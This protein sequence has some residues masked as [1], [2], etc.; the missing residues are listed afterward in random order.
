[1]VRTQ[2]VWDWSMWNYLWWWCRQ[3]PPS[4]QL[5]AKAWIFW[6]KFFPECP[7]H[8]DEIVFCLFRADQSPHYIWAFDDEDRARNETVAELN[9]RSW[10]LGEW[11][12]AVLFCWNDPICPPPQRSCQINSRMYRQR[13]RMTDIW[14]LNNRPMLKWIFLEMW[15]KVDSSHL[16]STTPRLLQDVMV[17][18]IFI[19]GELK[20]NTTFR[21][22]AFRN[23]WNQSLYRR[24]LYHK[25]SRKTFDNCCI[26]PL[27][28][29]I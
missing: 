10:R 23:P 17:E 16:P 22:H 2:Q 4:N 5:S 13:T 12:R 27:F 19:M 11:K 8:L 20:K 15:F 25:L 9:I 29:H 18:A 21:L 3:R 1:M 14:N 28:H 6:H 7:I 26:I 24:V